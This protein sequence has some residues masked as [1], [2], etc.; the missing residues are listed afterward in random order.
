LA[1][2]LT[3]K[4]P[5]RTST[6]LGPLIEFTIPSLDAAIDLTPLDIVPTGF[7]VLGL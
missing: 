4:A 3:V 7:D 2:D 5:T 1:R 6:P